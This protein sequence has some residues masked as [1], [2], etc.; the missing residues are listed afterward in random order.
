MIAHPLH[1]VRG[2]LLVGLAPIALVAC[3]DSS[4][5]TGTA[6]VGGTN[7]SV[8]LRAEPTSLTPRTLGATGLV[9]ASVNA[10]AASGPVVVGL[11]NDTLKIE[12]VKL[13]FDNVRLRKTGVSAC[14]DSIK[15]AGVDRTASDVAGCARLDLGA[16]VVD[17][18]L[19][20]SDTAAVSA[21]IPAGSYRAAKFNLRR[22]RVGPGAT[23]RD[24]IMLA[25]NPDM[26][27]ASIRV[28]G[29]YRDSSF[30]FFSRAS[31]EIEFEFEPPLVVTADTPNN[32]TISVHPSR[33]FVGPNGGILSPA[34]ESN[35]GLINAAIHNAFEAFE[36][37]RRDG[38]GD[39]SNRPKK[40][41]TS[42]ETESD[43]TRARP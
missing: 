18:P 31:A 25:A 28:A 7:M 24:S 9:S 21:K 13:V 5:T 19:N 34:L 17:V 1:R 29:K 2:A 10:A 3:G 40:S 8:A 22:I 39:D 41:G 30:V 4:S 37:H 16:M 11:N 15:P 27:G 14:L 36:D 23:A 33:W 20:A 35:R 6:A 42:H 26:A 12:S 32:L 43:T 38:H